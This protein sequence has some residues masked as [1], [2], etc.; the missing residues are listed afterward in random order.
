[1]KRIINIIFAVS[2]LFAFA[3]ISFAQTLPKYEK[4][5]IYYKDSG[6]GIAY[7]KTITPPN[8]QGEY[9]IV[10][11]SFVTGEVKMKY[12]DAPAD[13]ILHLDMS[14]SMSASMG[15]P[16]PVTQRTALSYNSVVAPISIPN[17]DIYLY[18]TTGD[19][20]RQISAQEY[21]GRY[22]L[23]CAYYGANNQHYKYLSQ[24][25]NGNISLINATSKTPPANAASSD[26]KDGAIITFSGANTGNNNRLY[27][28][29]SRLK[30]LQD[31]VCVFIDE[32]NT[33]DLYAVTE[34]GDTLERGDRLGNRIALITFERQ[35]HVLFDLT[36]L[37]DSSIE[38]MKQKVYEMEMA[39]GTYPEDGFTRAH[40][41]YVESDRIYPDRKK[42]STRTVVFFTDGHPA[43]YDA[44][45][46]AYTVK[47]SDNAI[48]YTVGLFDSRP[49][50]DDLLFLHY[51]SSD[52]PDARD[53]DTPGTGGSD[54]AGYYQ[55]ASD[56]ELT[57]I[58]RKIAQES[59]GSG[60]TSLGSAVTAVDVVSASFVLPEGASNKVKIYTAPVIG[61]QEGIAQ[62]DTTYQVEVDGEMVTR[63]WLKFGTQKQIP[64]S[65]DTYEKLD[66]DGKPIE[67]TVWVDVDD[68]IKFT[69]TPAD[70]PNTIR[71]NGFDYSGNWCGEYKDIDGNP[72][73]EYHGHKVII[74]IPIKMSPDAVGGPHVETNAPGSGIYVN[75]ESDQPLVK[76]ESPN[77]SLPVN[78]FIQKDGLKEGESAK[79]TIQRTFA[80]ASSSSSWEDVTSVFVTRSKGATGSPVTKV[81]GMPS[82]DDS[83]KE[84]V[85]RI[86]EEGW[87]WSYTPSKEYMLSTEIIT[88][89]FIFNNTEKDAI[90]YRVRHAESKA[91]NTFTTKTGVNKVEYD[92]SKTNDR[93]DSK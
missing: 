55:D 52:Y 28:G 45:G 48:V 70:K 40:D 62:A 37:S 42:S 71:V 13:I 29:S 4:D 32:I 72:T 16:T 47:S 59:G 60:N 15:T 36:F 87:S 58:F 6:N 5:R 23:Y 22:Y 31:A 49:T 11:E 84:Y 44:I 51:T 67:P 74:V 93:G 64:T 8:P 50:G 2:V 88:N 30:E 89:P 82:T 26:T 79:F 27:T 18:S 53:I 41:Q 34:S 54:S 77:V 17:A 80:P 39:Q 46:Q 7:S 63:H 86:K 83:G 14:S 66:D 3:P 12:E 91:T 85:Y 56:A 65:T 21:N 75:G 1:M 10:L 61:I 90:D 20:Y 68:S 25:A 9:D 57:E 69:L 76:F 81:M 24:A 92:D 78:I 73:G 43:N 19:G 35:T 33:N 38:T